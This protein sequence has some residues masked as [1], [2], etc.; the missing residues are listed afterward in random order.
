MGDYILGQLLS[1]NVDSAFVFL[2]F[3]FPLQVFLKIVFTLVAEWFV[4]L[5]FRARFARLRTGNCLVGVRESPSMSILPS[6]GAS[7]N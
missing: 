7:V 6:V 5:Q 2:Y 4:S 1:G 3:G